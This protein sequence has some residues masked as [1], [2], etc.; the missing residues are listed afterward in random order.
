MQAI[1]NSIYSLIC[2][3]SHSRISFPA[4]DLVFTNHFPDFL[5]QMINIS[6]SIDAF[7][8][9]LEKM[10]EF[11]AYSVDAPELSTREVLGNSDIEPLLGEMLL[12]P[13]CYYGSACPDDI[14]F[15]TFVMLFDAIFKQGWPVRSVESVRFL[16]HSVVNW[17]NWE[18]KDA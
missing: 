5:E 18:S 10:E 17:K 6:K 14:D 1:K 13:T 15:P 2:K 12:C 3:E 4:K 9:L 8:K 11:P 7:T 16:T